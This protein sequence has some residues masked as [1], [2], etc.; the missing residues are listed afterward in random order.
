ME[1]TG[2]SPQLDAEKRGL[3][4]VQIL[5]HDGERLFSHTATVQTSDRLDIAV[6]EDVVMEQ[7][8]VVA[9]FLELNP[10]E[11]HVDIDVLKLHLDDGDLGLSDLGEL[12]HPWCLPENVRQFSEEVFVS[13]DM[14]RSDNQS[15][16]VRPRTIN[17]LPVRPERENLPT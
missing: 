2:F 4:L 14:P 3:E 5:F 6:P 12:L 16:D 8:K 15:I 7:L 9:D 1:A 10:G 13:V 11:E 17:T